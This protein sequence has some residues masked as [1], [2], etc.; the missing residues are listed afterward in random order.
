VERIWSD[1]LTS[2]GT[3]SKMG[4][5]VLYSFRFMRTIRRRLKKNLPACNADVS[6]NSE[7]RVK[8]GTKILK[9]IRLGD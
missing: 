5:S 4:S 2:S 8:Q 6:L 9:T 7:M 3:R 1:G